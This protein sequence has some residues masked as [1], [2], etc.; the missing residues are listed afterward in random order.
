MPTL[1]PTGEVAPALSLEGLRKRFGAVAAIDG[2]SLAVPSRATLALL[3]PSGCGKTTI[4]RS[5]AGFVELDE[6]AIRIGGR[7]VTRLPPEARG[8]GMVFQNYALFPHMTVAENVAFGLKMHRVSRPERAERVASALS[9]V[10]LGALAD[11]Y[12]AELSGGQQQRTALA[13]AVAIRPDLLLLDEPFGALDENLRQVMQIEL[14]KLQQRL[15]LTTVI[16][17]HDQEEAMIVGDLIA[18][19]RSG[20]IEQI[21]PPSTLYDR[22]ATRF[23]ADFM[24][25]ENILDARSD[26]R[27]IHLGAHR[28]PCRQRGSDASPQGAVAVAVRAEAVTVER[29]G[30][31]GAWP[32][33]VAFATNLGGRILYEIDVEGV[34][35]IKSAEPRNAGRS[36]L[37]E[38]TPVAVRIAPESLTVLGS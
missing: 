4:L 16:V 34:G 23:V 15:G 21:A 12:P 32:G 35:R 19:V 6:G 9:L 29:D 25:V 24:G 22:P 38:G 31:E 10:Q 37:P 30:R 11:R 33:R 7:D 1:S 26:G 3:G 5:I 18:V 20:R 28:L 27:E 36:G 8:T 13:R 2:V 17:T 14:R